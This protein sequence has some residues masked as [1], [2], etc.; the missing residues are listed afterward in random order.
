MFVGFR[1]I[2]GFNRCNALLE[3]KKFGNVHKNSILMLCETKF[4][5][6][7]STAAVRSA[8]LAMLKFFPP[9]G[10]LVESG[11]CGRYIPWRLFHFLFCIKRVAFGSACNIHYHLSNV[12]FIVVFM[13]AL[14]KYH[15]KNEFWIDLISYV[16]SLL[17]V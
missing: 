1:N 15:E 9:L 2:R 4:S 14:A 17:L 16:N 7:P 6:S 10:S 5:A 3:V 11:S 13:Y 12:V 8:V